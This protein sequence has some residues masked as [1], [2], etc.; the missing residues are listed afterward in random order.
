MEAT[1]LALSDV[2]VDSEIQQR[3]N[4]L[5]AATINEYAAQYEAG[6]EM[7][8]IVAFQ[9]K[10]EMI[11]LSDG[12]HRYAAQDLLGRESVDVDLR[13]GTRRDAILFACA[14][15]SS[16]GLRRTNADKRKAIT[17]LLSDEAWAKR[18]DR[19]VA[20]KVGVG[21][22]LVG[23]VRTQLDESSSS[24]KGGVSQSSLLSDDEPADTEPT[25][26]IGRDGKERTSKPQSAIKPIKS[27][28][29]SDCFHQYMMNLAGIQDGL[30]AKYE[31]SVSRMVESGDWDKSRTVTA[32]NYLDESIKAFQSIRKE[33]AKHVG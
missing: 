30:L 28:P 17:T 13:K 8:P 11:W 12:F 1:C 26:T 4:G 14:A 10:D 27:Y 24:Q 2:T 19:W 31:R 32:L 21:H 3:A 5:D 6:T 22:Q 18:S 7:P 33:L 9:D 15:N 25:K 23:D 16:H 20:D 29:A